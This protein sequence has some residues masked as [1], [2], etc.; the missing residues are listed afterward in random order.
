MDNQSNVKIDEKLSNSYRKA[1][2]VELSF[3]F[4][5]YGYLIKNITIS[6]GGFIFTGDTHSWLAAT[7]Y[8]APLMANYDTRLSNNSYI[9]YVDN[10]TAFTVEWENV[11][12]QDEPKAGEFTF[13]TTLLKNGD[14]IFA[15][16]AIPLIIES[17]SDALHPVKVGVSDAY[18]ITRSVFDVNKKT[19]YEYHRVNLK[20]E[21]IKNS[22]VIYLNALP[23]CLDSKDCDTCLTQ[24]IPN[25]ECAWCPSMNLCSNGRDRHRQD[26]LTMK[27][28]TEK[29]V[30]EGQCSKNE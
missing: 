22:T 21:N 27:C 9:K 24:V 11:L 23:T 2:I 8:I 26:W 14:I 28:D 6:T 16:K 1:T 3:D 18:I 29:L 13:Q 7:Q 20:E 30:D 4:P 10:G 5:F 17:I 12:L 25:L 19:I 15:Y